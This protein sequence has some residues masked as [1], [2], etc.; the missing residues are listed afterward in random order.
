MHWQTHD[1]G[2]CKNPAVC[3]SVCQVNK[4]QAQL[5]LKELGTTRPGEVLLSV[6]FLCLSFGNPSWHLCCCAWLQLSPCPA[7]CSWGQGKLWSIVASKPF[8]TYFKFIVQ[9]VCSHTAGWEPVTDD[10]P[11]PWCLECGTEL[12]WASTLRRSLPATAV[13]CSGPA[14]GFLPC[15]ITAA[16]LS[17]PES[18]THRADGLQVWLCLLHN[19]QVS[20]PW[21]HLAWL[22][23]GSSERPGQP[24]MVGQSSWFKQ[25]MPEKLN[26]SK[27]PHGS[28]FY[29]LSLRIHRK[30]SVISG[31]KGGLFE[32]FKKVC[33]TARSNSLSL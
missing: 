27:S 23:E 5:C 24:G 6:K 10:C 9:K 29:R 28:R 19:R 14:W 21:T 30:L 18:E 26:T 2:R 8:P 33:T 12:C 11:S 1:M 25:E 31:D 15:L 32:A 4:N 17:S 7:P 20:C 22:G 3:L 13:M 16:E